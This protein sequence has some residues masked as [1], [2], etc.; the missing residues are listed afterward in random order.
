MSYPPYF[1]FGAHCYISTTNIYTRKKT[2]YLTTKRHGSFQTNS[3][4]MF[5]ANKQTLTF[6]FLSIFWAPRSCQIH[7]KTQI[8][9]RLSSQ[10][11]CSHK[12]LVK[13]YT[14]PSVRH[15][16]HLCTY[17]TTRLCM[18]IWHTCAPLTSFIFVSV[19]VLVPILGL[20]MI[21]NRINLDPHLLRFDWL[22]VCSLSWL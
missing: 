3:V 21:E 17:K 10:R 8:L 1:L 12:F 19:F 9:L 2:L 14:S 22:A 4:R 6:P 7:V 16:Y 13:T 18:Y 15:A 11:V 5:Y 20:N